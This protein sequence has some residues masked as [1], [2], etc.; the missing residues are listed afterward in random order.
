[1]IGTFAGHTPRIWTR[2]QWR[3]DLS[4]HRFTRRRRQR[5]SGSVDRP[6]RLDE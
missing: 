2:E 6:T 3:P 5:W 1:M 4:G